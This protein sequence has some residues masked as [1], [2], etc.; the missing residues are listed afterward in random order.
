MTATATMVRQDHENDFSDSDVETLFDE[1]SIGTPSSIQKCKAKL[2]DSAA[3]FPADESENE[4]EENT[5]GN[6]EIL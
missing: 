6:D 4:N 5:E 1:W 3:T 2:N